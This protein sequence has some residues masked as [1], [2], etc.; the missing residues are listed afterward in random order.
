MLKLR[1]LGFIVCTG[2]QAVSRHVTPFCVLPVCFLENV[3]GIKIFNFDGVQYVFFPLIDYAFGF[4]S[5]K[6]L[7]NLRSPSLISLVPSKS[8]VIL[9]IAIGLLGLILIPNRPLRSLR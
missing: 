1:H 7:L 9:L 5:K 3:L 8:F 2:H 6:R 4:L